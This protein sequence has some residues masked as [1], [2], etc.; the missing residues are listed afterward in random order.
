M[1]LFYFS[2]D[3]SGG[4]YLDSNESK[5]C[6]KVLRHQ[7]GDQIHGVDGKGTKYTAVI[8]AANRDRVSLTILDRE[9]NWGEHPYEVHL[10]VSPL[11]LRDRFEWLLEKAV[12]L[13]VTR[14]QPVIC[15]RTIRTQFK[16]ERFQKI[17]LSAL[18]QSMRSRLP[19]LSS[20]IPLV[21]YCQQVGPQML[22]FQA[23][24]LDTL[25]NHKDDISQ[26]ST[27]HLVIGP[28]GD[29]SPEEIALLETT[30]KGLS[31]GSNRLRTETAAIHALSSVKLI[32]G[33]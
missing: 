27:F 11:R 17:L 15:Q 22:F 30:G 7:A 3:P 12:E 21:T 4:A 2:V 19:V 31:L 29:F 9:I 18:K 20:P 8:D 13:G 32:K 6:I 10:A 5:H 26:Q 1:Q 33:W 14:I 23:N 16:T 25:G 28:E 24:S